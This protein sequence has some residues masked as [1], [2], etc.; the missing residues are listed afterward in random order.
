[1][2][3]L[4]SNCNQLIPDGAAHCPACKHPVEIQVIASER[5]VAVGGDINAPVFTGDINAPVRLEYAALPEIPPPPEPD[6]P[7]VL[8][9]FVGRQAELAY[10]S[11]KLAKEHIAVIT[12]MAGVG[13]T[14]LAAELL[15][16]VSRDWKIFW[17]S[18]HETEGLDAL[19]W[20]LAAFLA[21]HDQPELWRMLQRAR[22]SG[23]QPPPVE[24][25]FN[26]LLQIL[27]GGNYLLCFDDFQFIDDDPRLGQFIGDLRASILQGEISI[28]VTSRRMPAFVQVV[29]F[30]PLAGLNLSDVRSLLVARDVELPEQGLEQL[31]TLTA[32]N[33]EFLTLAAEA[34]RR[35]ERPLQLIE[36]LAQA[37]DI[38]N[39]LM[40]Q[41]DERLSDL[42]RDVMS[43]VAVFLGYPARRLKRCWMQA[44]SCAL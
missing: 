32:G 28:V 13:K 20:D 43:A 40:A 14:A 1:M 8:A 21:W 16:R 10:Y 22:L 9:D 6:R 7:P 36:M 18:A 19:L 4:C 37:Q 39:Y 2:A 33:A 30:E 44:V 42:Q 35:A 5:G 11:E 24:V 31:H 15:K 3:I 17:H 34:L 41:V 12:G 26:Y 29:Q 23:G 27:R 25:V 38:E